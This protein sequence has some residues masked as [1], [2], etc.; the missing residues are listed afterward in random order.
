MTDFKKIPKKKS[1]WEM[2]EIEKKNQSLNGR[3]S[4]DQKKNIWSKSLEK[5][6]FLWPIP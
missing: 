6:R 5:I 1:N 3:S 2:K 4:N